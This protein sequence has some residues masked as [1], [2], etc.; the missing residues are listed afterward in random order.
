MLCAIER[1][2]LEDSG[3]LRGKEQDCHFGRVMN[4]TNVGAIFRS[5]A[6][7]HM[8]AVL[9]TSGC[10]NPLLSKSIQSE[11][12]NGVSDPMDIYSG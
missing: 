4:P 1:E 2:P 9:L 5:A 8:D 7:M 12:G 10:S 3:T 11:Y 6:A